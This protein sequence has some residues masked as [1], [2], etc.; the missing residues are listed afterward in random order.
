M[1]LYIVNYPIILLNNLDWEA[2]VEKRSYV[3][4]VIDYMLQADTMLPSY[5][6]FY[7]SYM[8]PTTAKI[9]VVIIMYCQ[10]I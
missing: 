4:V 8:T 10:Y 7:Q 2:M 3:M 9:E 6:T 1:F 5:Y